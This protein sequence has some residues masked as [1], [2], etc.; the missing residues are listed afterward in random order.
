[1]RV[2]I[3]ITPRDF[4]DETVAK[5]MRMFEKWGVEAVIV[6][7]TS[8]SKE[9]VGVHGAVY[10]PQLNFSKLNTG[11]FDAIFLVDGEGVETYKLYDLMPM[12]DLLRS[13]SESGKII[14]G[15]NNAVKI[16]ARANIVANKK[17]AIPKDP[18]VERLVRLYKGVVSKEE[19][20]CQT[21]IMTLNDYSK[22]EEFVG[23]ILDK[24]SI[25]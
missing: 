1:M 8:N 20:E 15:V 3:V 24:A 7:F 21:N 19:M 18:E 23:A 13:F 2:A 22:T 12:L 14:A 5:A 10:K 16:I 17:I 4:R 25:R 6:G 11:D 9:C